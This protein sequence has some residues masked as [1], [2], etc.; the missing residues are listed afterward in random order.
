MAD[1]GTQFFLRKEDVGSPRAAVTV[2]RL[3]ELNSYVPVHDLGG[4]VGEVL[5]EETLAKYQ[6]SLES[7]AFRDRLRSELEL[8]QRAHSLTP[9]RSPR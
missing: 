1:L 9:L 6:V 2:P 4:Q 7:H 5:S 3:A 8:S